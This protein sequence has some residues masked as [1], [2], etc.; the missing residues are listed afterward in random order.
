MSMADFYGNP[1]A[2]VEDEE[3]DVDHVAAE[4]GDEGINIMHNS[5]SSEESDDDSEAEREVAEGTFSL[6]RY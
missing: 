6:S 5:D 4:S 2:G 1:T 3:D